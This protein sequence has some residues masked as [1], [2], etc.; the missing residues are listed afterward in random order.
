MGYG[1]LYDSLGEA[2]AALGGKAAFQDIL[3]ITKPTLKIDGKLMR[4][5]EGTLESGMITNHELVREFENAM[6]SYLGSP[7]AVALANCTSGLMLTLKCLE[8]RGEV[9]LPSF[10]FVASAHSVLWNGLRPRFVECDPLTF[11]ISPEAVA[12]AIGPETSAIMGVHIFGNPAPIGELEEIAGDAKIPLIFDSA[13][14]MGAQYRGKKIGNF[15]DAEIFSFSPTKLVV[16][17]EGGAVTTGS[18]ELYDNLIVGRNYG[19][20][21]DYDCPFAGLS[22]RLPEINAALGLSSL[23]NIEDFVGR[24][25]ELADKYRGALSMGGLRFQAVDP[26]NRATYKDFALVVNEEEFGLTRDVLELAL[27]EEGISTRK[28]FD[29]P[30]HL[31][32]AYR[33]FGPPSLPVTEGLARNILCIPMFTHMSEDILEKVCFAIDRI[34]GSAEELAKQNNQGPLV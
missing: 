29:P 13:H 4:R 30:V 2:P 22:A 18:K 14:G 11:N 20:P 32:K 28:Y 19:N 7:F 12:E 23:A 31:Q 3:P 1:T 27:A 5:I 26:G 24:R 9:I 33:K 16:A 15:G 25:N 21:G 17:G 6:V 10:T 8:L 34:V